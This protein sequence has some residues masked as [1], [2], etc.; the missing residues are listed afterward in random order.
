MKRTMLGIIIIVIIAAAA[1][2]LTP[3]ALAGN[4]TVP[5]TRIT[6]NEA[7]GS[8]TLATDSNG[9]PI[10]TNSTSTV[11]AYEYYFS[12]RPGGWFRTTE[13]KVNA[14]AGSAN[15]NFTLYISTPSGSQ[16]LPMQQLNGVALGNRTH[17]IYLSVDQGLR[18]SGT[19][20][21]S[22]SVSAATKTA[23]ATSYGASK[24]TGLDVTWKVP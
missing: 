23:T 17:T 2:L 21:L 13:N 14:S 18:A 16:T 4:V 15:I 7:T 22:I 9:N 19:Y 20:H 12:I 24:A 10:S 8:L 1:V 11:T 5:V 6:F 3:I